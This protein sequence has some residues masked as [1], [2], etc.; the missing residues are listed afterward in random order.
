MARGEAK[1]AKEK[2]AEA[3]EAQNGAKPKKKKAGGNLFLW[4][5]IAITVSA[6]WWA[7]KAMG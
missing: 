6:V 1:A 2:V 5:L 4:I 3:S 7:Q